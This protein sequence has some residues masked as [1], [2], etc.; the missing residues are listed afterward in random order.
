MICGAGCGSNCQSDF[1]QQKQITREREIVNFPT[2]GLVK[3][4]RNNPR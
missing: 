1:P 2:D 3:I 4:R